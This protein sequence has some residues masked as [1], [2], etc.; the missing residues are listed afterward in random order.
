[1]GMRTEIAPVRATDSKTGSPTC[2]FCET[3]AEWRVE[4]PRACHAE[5]C[6]LHR[7]TLEVDAESAGYVSI[8]SRIDG[9]AVALTAVILA[10]LL[11]PG[12]GKSSDPFTPLFIFAVVA[13]A[14][15]LLAVIVLLTTRLGRALG[16]V[17]TRDES[18][19]DGVGR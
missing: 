3:E 6:D 18:E 15:L 1:M 7:A 11:L 13:G 2:S 4:I 5:T 16:C 14:L 8:W 12:C 10:A 17:E 19:M 9:N